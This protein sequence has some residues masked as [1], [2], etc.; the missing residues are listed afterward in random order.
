[1]ARPKGSGLVLVAWGAALAALVAVSARFEAQHVGAGRQVWLVPLVGAL[2]AVAAYVVRGTTTVQVLLALTAAAWLLGSVNPWLLLAHQGMLL[3]TLLAFPTGQLEGW[4]RYVAVLALPVALGMLAAPVVGLVF[5]AVGASALHRRRT[6]ATVGAAAAGGLVGSALGGLWLVREIDPAGL[7]PHAWLLGYEAAIL[8]AAGALALGSRAEARRQRDLVDR[9]L[10]GSG[11]T[12]LVG[13]A[14]VLADALRAPGLE[15]AGPSSPGA[16]RGE[17]IIRDDDR[18]MAVV[19]HPSVATLDDTTRESVVAAV[20]LVARGE[21]RREALA[22]QVSALEAIQRRMVSAQDEQR[23]AVAER[24]RDDVVAPLATAA[25]QLEGA[26]APRDPVAAAAVT[27]A[28]GQIRAARSELEEL[29]NGAGPPGL[30]QG[31][32]ADALAEMAARSPVA[33]S[34]SLD[35]GAAST[36]EV[37]TTLYYV[38]AEALVNVHRHA[39]ADVA[40]VELVHDDHGIRLTVSDDG[41]GG[42]EP[43]GSGL[44]GLADRVRMHGGRLRVDSPPGA[45]TTVIAYWSTRTQGRNERW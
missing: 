18:V 32:L 27:V 30:G 40:L 31:R 43:A 25:A 33:V 19:R 15:I 16:S 9:L 13:L 45:G 21:A 23:T 7:D 37:E 8:A 38:C 11:R 5:C 22:A 2:L 20:R 35:G 26:L 36:P 29:V 24:L 17:L 28:L 3:L 34:L 42:A 1:M 6:P 10:A 44:L 12:G 39:R 14:A 4:A 41:V